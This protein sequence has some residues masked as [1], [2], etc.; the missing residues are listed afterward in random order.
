MSDCIEWRGCRKPDGYGL[1]NVDGRTR[2]AHRVAYEK[3]HGPIPDGMFVC[4]TCDNRGCVNPEHLWLGT[5]ADNMRDMA[6][7]G[8]ARGSRGER[9][10]AAKLTS[11]LVAEIRQRAAVGELQKDLA[12]E[13]GVSRSTVSKVATGRL[14]GHS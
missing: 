8:R 13:Y 5:P 1:V 4:H 11:A 6:E 14:W 3:V 10:H 12:A 2:R 9:H 7:K